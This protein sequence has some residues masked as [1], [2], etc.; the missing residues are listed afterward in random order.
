LSSSVG[1][2][3]IFSLTV[4]NIVPGTIFLPIGLLITGWTTQSHIFWLVPDIVS[5]DLRAFSGSAEG[6]SH[7]QGIVFVG[8]GSIVVVQSVQAYL[9]DA[10]TLHAASGVISASS[11][12]SVLRAYTSSDYHSSC[13]CYVLA[14][15]GRL[16]ISV[17]CPGDV[18]CA[19]LRQ[20]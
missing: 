5:D 16:R 3:D 9:I 13:G 11:L 8:A 18:Q 1:P 17:V 14:L 12:S 4:A 15:F 6:H 19:G 7:W 20:G 10:F 2:N